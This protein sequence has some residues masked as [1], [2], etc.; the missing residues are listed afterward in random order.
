MQIQPENRIYLPTEIIVD[1]K[2]VQK[3]LEELNLSSGWLDQQ[4]IN[5]GITSVEEVFFAELQSD[6]SLHISKKNK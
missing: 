1:G 4:L 3:N 6:G 2:L 5:A